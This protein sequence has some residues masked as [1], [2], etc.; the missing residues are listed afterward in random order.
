MAGHLFLAAGMLAYLSVHMAH[1]ASVLAAGLKTQC[2]FG[3]VL[4][5][6]ELS[7]GHDEQDAAPSIGAMM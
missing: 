1:Q 3:Q 6:V 4:N 5:D 2:Q 7:A